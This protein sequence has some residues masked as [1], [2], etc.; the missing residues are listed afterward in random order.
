MTRRTKPRLD[1][2]ILYEPDAIMVGLLLFPPRACGACGD[3]LP[4]CR[5]YFAPDAHTSDGMRTT[6]RRC[7]RTQ[8]RDGER[9]RAQRRRDLT[10]ATP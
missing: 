8:Q 4:R 3:T 1:D 7:R 9:V 10:K 5:D 2:S 6:C